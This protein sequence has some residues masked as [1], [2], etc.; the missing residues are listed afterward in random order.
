MI[1][2]CICWLVVPALQAKPLCVDTEGEG[3][4]MGADAPSARLEAFN[5]AKW[6]AVE[7]VAGVDVKSR[8]MV[9]DSALLDDL[10]TTQARGVVTGAT[11]RSESREGDTI[12]VAAQVCVESSGARTA[13]AALAVNASLSVYLPAR[14]LKQGAAAAYDDAN[15][16]AQ[17]VIG[18]LADKGFT[19]RDIADSHALKLKDMDK[20]MKNGNDQVV[21]SLIYRFL[22]TAV[23]IG[24][25]EPT[26][27]FSKGDDAGYGI[28]M[29][30]NTV[31]AR[32]SY[33][34]LTR[35]ASGRMVVLAAGTEEARGLA[36][37]ADDA[38]MEAQK[39]LAEKFVPLIADKLT[40]RLNDLATRIT[41]QVDGVSQ[42]AETMAVR[43]AISRITW[44][45]NVEETGLGQFRVSFPENPLYLANGLSQKGFRIVSY[46]RDLIRVRKP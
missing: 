22:A 5:R 43:D 16:L 6:A 25:I 27:S 37:N 29:P 11:I 34:L 14:S 41:V 7:Q 21:R 17:A 9:T 28:K 36:P 4:I 42:P 3:V 18:K 35:D 8:T 44:V 24:K 1:F 33:R 20:A 31:T 46:S 38:Y 45:N 13:V 19:V 10:I 23:L 32:L 2:V 12:R 15:P 39:N 26:L 40:A 30:F